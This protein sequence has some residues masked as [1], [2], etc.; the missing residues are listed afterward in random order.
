[1]YAAEKGYFCK[2]LFMTEQHF[3][4]LDVLFLVTDSNFKAA[5]EVVSKTNNTK[6]D[7][8]GTFMLGYARHDIPFV[9]MDIYTSSEGYVIFFFSSILFAFKSYGKNNAEYFICRHKYIFE[10]PRGGIKFRHFF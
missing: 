8:L 4:N 1:M 9:L 6:F 7:E 5:S 3:D 10:G 2:N